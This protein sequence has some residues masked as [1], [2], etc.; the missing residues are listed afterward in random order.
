MQDFK[1]DRFG[2]AD[3]L[4]QSGFR[5]PCL[6]GVLQDRMNDYGIAFGSVPV[7]NTI[8]TSHKYPILGFFRHGWGSL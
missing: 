3:R 4:L 1:F 6:I 8:L 5:R 7:P 2:E